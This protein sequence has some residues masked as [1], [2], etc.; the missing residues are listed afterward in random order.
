MTVLVTLFLFVASKYENASAIGG[1]ISHQHS[2]H[3]APP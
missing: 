3:E 2:G 1:S